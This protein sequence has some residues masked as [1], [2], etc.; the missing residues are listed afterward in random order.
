MT[1]QRPKP[2]MITQVNF[3]WYPLTLLPILALGY[4]ALMNWVPAWLLVIAVFGLLFWVF[5]LAF[6]IYS[7][8]AKR[9]EPRQ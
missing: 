4:G 3:V 5:S 1:P 8:F 7:L 6:A 9:S 2:V